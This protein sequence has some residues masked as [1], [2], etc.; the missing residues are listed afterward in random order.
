VDG[1]RDI[2]GVLVVDEYLSTDATSAITD[3]MVRGVHLTA[4]T[5]SAPVRSTS[6]TGCTCNAGW[7]GPDGGTCT[8]FEAGKYQ[9]LSGTATCTDCAAGTFSTAV[10]A[11]ATSTCSACPSNSNSSAGSAAFTTCA[12]SGGY[13]QRLHPIA[14]S[15]NLYPAYLVAA[16]ESWDSSQ[17]RFLD[18]SRSGRVGMLQTGAVS[19]G[20]LT[21]NG[22][23]WSVPYVGGTTG[24]Q[25]SW[26]AAS[27][28]SNFTICSITRYSGVAKRRILHRKELVTRTLDG[29]CSNI[30]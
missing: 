11:S 20:S 22:A 19:I 4:D 6:L 12:C 17:Q 7:T 3:L 8:A 25:F 26:G 28:P 15:L 23:F 30:L 13:Y 1:K 2:S 24:T 29:Q 14:D 16:A 5:S 18:L 9:T 27:I 21:G 10:G